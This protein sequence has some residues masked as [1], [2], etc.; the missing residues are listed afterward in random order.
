MDIE[1]FKL[2]W[3]IGVSNKRQLATRLKGRQQIGQF[4]VGKLATYVLSKRLS[5]ASKCNGKFYAASMDYTA[6]DTT[7]NK[8]IQPTTPI[9]IVLRGT[10]RSAGSTGQFAHYWLDGYARRQLTALSISIRCLKSETTRNVLF[11]G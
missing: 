9:R 10:Y 3:L 6:I 7:I 8:G 5:H 2:H 11:R 4:G 1:G